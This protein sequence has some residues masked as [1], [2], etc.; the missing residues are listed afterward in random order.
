[1]TNEA[2]IRVS[3]KIA[4]TEALLDVLSEVFECTTTEVAAAL[5]KCNIVSWDDLMTSVRKN[6]DEVMSALRH[7]KV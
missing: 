1:M 4:D 2:G 6:A 5:K 3:L 7:E